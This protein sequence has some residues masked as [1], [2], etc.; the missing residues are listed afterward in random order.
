MGAALAANTGAAGAMHRV[1]FFAAKAAP[2]GTA[3]LSRLSLYLWERPCVAKGPQRG[4]RIDAQQL[5]LLGLLCSPFA[6]Q[7]RS[8]RDRA[9]F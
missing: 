3:L 8:H 7:G 4:P 6:T 5:K 2:T 9:N 1:E